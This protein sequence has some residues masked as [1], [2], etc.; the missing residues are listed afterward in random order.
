MLRYRCHTGHAYNAD[1]VLASQNEEIDRLLYTLLRS[2]QE[3]AALARRMAEYE[4]GLGRKLLAEQFERRAVEYDD[5]AEVMRN[6]IRDG[7]AAAEVVTTV[8]ERSL[9]HDE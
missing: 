8:K 9:P 2:H 1:T 4:R 7:A 5:D 6:L 3:R